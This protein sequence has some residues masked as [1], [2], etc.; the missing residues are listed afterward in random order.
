MTFPTGFSCGRNFSRYRSFGSGLK[1]F[2]HVL[3]TARHSKFVRGVRVG[4]VVKESCY[5]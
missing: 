1:R 4:V 3:I 5:E 2:T